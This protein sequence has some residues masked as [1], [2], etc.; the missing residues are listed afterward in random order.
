MNCGIMS[1]WFLIHRELLSSHKTNTRTSSAAPVDSTHSTSGVRG[2]KTTQ[3]SHSS[4]PL[5]S[6]QCVR[7]S[8]KLL[9]KSYFKFNEKGASTKINSEAFYDNAS[10]VVDDEIPT[11]AVHATTPLSTQNVAAG[12]RDN[13]VAK[14]RKFLRNLRDH[15][16]HACDFST[17]LNIL[18]KINEE[19]LKPQIDNTSHVQTES[20]LQ[21][22]RR[23]F[24][25]QP[26]VLQADADKF[27]QTKR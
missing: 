16:S 15:N 10:Q 2:E 27:F 12:R 20:S 18:L 14:N 5:R 11:A 24:S 9:K 21:I 13:A 4:S 7:K 26:K 22:R 1:K 6:K 25:S 3:V 8:P 17:S 19:D 23:R